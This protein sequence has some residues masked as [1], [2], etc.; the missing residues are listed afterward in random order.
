[1]ATRLGGADVP[2]FV[3]QRDDGSYYTTPKP[4]A[5]EGRV[6][7]IVFPFSDHVDLLLQRERDWAAHLRQIQQMQP[8][9]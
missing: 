8:H 5:Y 1:M 4:P 2:H 3:V 9:Q 7:D 6:T